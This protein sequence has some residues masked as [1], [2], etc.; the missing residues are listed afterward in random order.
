[1]EEFRIAHQRMFGGKEN[2]GTLLGKIRARAA[3][4]EEESEQPGQQQQLSPKLEA[5]K[6]QSCI[7]EP[8]PPMR[9]APMQ[10]TKVVSSGTNRSHTKEH[11]HHQQHPP[12][13]PTASRM[14]EKAV[15][16]QHREIYE[17]TGNLSATATD[18]TTMANLANAANRITIK[19]LSPKIGS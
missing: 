18:R 15:L 14:R 19:V 8:P 10:M 3:A 16:P 4:L 1:M 2:N 9:E 6:A 7:P 17:S 5:S 11:Y 13:P 12:P